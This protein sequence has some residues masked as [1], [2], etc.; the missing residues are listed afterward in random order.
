MLECNSYDSIAFHWGEPEQAP[1]LSVVNV[2]VG[3]LRVHGV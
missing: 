2:Y 1:H 3:A